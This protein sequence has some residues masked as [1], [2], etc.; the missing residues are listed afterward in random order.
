ME[1]H[2]LNNRQMI[3][4]SDFKKIFVLESPDVKKMRVSQVERLSDEI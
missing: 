1:K 2:D 4:Y 3:R